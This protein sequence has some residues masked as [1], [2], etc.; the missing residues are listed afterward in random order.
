MGADSPAKLMLPEIDEVVA[1]GNV[2]GKELLPMG[3]ARKSMITFAFV[4]A[5]PGPWM[6]AWRVVPLVKPVQ[7]KE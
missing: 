4:A 2:A 5:S 1:V 3:S 7:V 6:C